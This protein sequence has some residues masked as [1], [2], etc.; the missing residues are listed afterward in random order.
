MKNIEERLNELF[1]ETDFLERNADK[2]N[3]DEIY[4]AVCAEIPD[5]KRDE[6]ESY[7]IA[8]SKAMDVGEVPENEL[9]NVAGGFSLLAACAT[10]TAVGGVI[11]IFYKGGKAIGEFIYNLKHK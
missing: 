9:D 4:A 3:F 11:A 8:V 5:V 2:G 10:I 7:L 6:L 1:G